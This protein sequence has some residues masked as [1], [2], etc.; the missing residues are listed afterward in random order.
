MA[1]TNP[2][3]LYHDII[4]LKSKTNIVERLEREKVY[5]NSNY[6]T[7]NS[8]KNGFTIYRNYLKE[9]LSSTLKIGDESLLKICLDVLIL[10]DKQKIDFKK[11]KSK[12]IRYDQTNLRLIYDVKAYIDKNILLL[13]SPYFIDNVLGL[14]ALTGRR[15]AEI[16]C[17]AKFKKVDDRTA[18][19]EG[20]LKIKGRKDILPYE[21][22]LLCDFDIIARSL[23]KIR[24]LKPKYK[25]NMELFH[26]SCS[27]TLSVKSKEIYKGLFEGTPKPRDLRAI[28]GCI[29]FH[30]FNK[31]LENKRIAEPIYI[32]Q[33][34]GHDDNDNYT[35]LSYKDFRID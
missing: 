32:S 29:C 27:K 14:A 15:V 21:I 25:D 30:E 9:N 34:L 10:T 8:L 2:A 35:C 19:F 18:I 7:V 3:K 28:Y 1:L 24:L 20:Q 33:I 5:L 17:T 16:G 4:C 11:L 26:N 13:D 23:N 31:K 6:N 22:P 12:N